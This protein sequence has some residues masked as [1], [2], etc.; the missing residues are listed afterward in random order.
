MSLHVIVIAGPNGAG[1]STAASGECMTS[2]DED[3]AGRFTNSQ[4]VLRLTQQ[5]VRAAVMEHKRVGNPIAI[6]RDGRVVWVPA[7][8]IEVPP[9]EETSGGEGSL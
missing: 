8:E 3:I 2:I 6:W 4:E 7:E 1:K 9:E 5:A